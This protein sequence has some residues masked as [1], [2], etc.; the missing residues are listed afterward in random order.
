LTRWLDANAGVSL[1]RNAATAPD[2]KSAFG[3]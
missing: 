2:L 3:L 1:L